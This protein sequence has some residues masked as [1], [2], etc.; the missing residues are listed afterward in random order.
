MLSL[1]NTL[2][3]C[4]NWFSTPNKNHDETPEARLLIIKT[5]TVHENHL[6]HKCIE[7]CVRDSHNVLGTAFYFTVQIFDAH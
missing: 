1:H 3:T 2:P 5:L 7:E 4:S 6:V